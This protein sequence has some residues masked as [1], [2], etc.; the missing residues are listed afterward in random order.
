MDF[1]SMKTFLPDRPALRRIGGS[2]SIFL[3][4]FGHAF[5]QA[6]AGL[7][8]GNSYVN[9]T[10]K[11]VGGPVE[12]GD[13]LEIRTNFYIKNDYDGA[14]MMYRVRYYDNLPT[15]TSIVPNDSLRLITNEGLTFRKYTL[16]SGDDA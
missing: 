2:L 14:G 12:P 8:F 10:K 9:L 6:T 5:S 15:F 11:T 7:K 13:I 4:T 3:L 16:A 1:I